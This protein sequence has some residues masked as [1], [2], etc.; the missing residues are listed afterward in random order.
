MG[1]W[2]N[3]ITLRS[4]PSRL[5]A[6]SSIAGNSH[7]YETDL[8]DQKYQELLDL[9]TLDEPKIDKLVRD[10][11]DDKYYN[12]ADIPFFFFR[13]TVMFDPEVV[14][15]WTF[16]GTAAAKTSHWDLLRAA[17]TAE[18]RIPVGG[19]ATFIDNDQTSRSQLGL[20]NP[21]LGIWA[22]FAVISLLAVLMILV[23]GW[24]VKSVWLV[25]RW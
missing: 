7:T 3:V 23:G 13:V 9:N 6:W 5:A 15:S 25:N 24:W 11:G 18:P 16:P 20:A 10:F 14:G 21:D 12:F 1:G 8:I 19:Q 4:G 2:G 17:S 22:T